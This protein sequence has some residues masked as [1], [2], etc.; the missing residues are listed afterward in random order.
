MIRVLVVDDQHLVR[1]GFQVL[2]DSAPDC[3]VVGEAENGLE[4][5]ALATEH[6]PDVVLMDIRMPELDGIEAT[7]RIVAD[8][9]NADTHV[10]V[11]TTFDLDEYVFEA[12]RAGASGFLLKDTRPADLLEAVRIVAGGEALLSPQVTRRVI[13]E[14]ATRPGSAAPG[15]AEALAAL[16]EREQE[17]LAQVGPGP[18]QHRDRRG[19]LRQPG[20]GQDPREPGHDQAARPRPGPAGRHRLRERVGH[21]RRQLIPRAYAAPPPYTLRPTPGSTPQADD[22]VRAPGGQ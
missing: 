20:D 21:P 9:A 19:P 10:L 1:A 3:E 22:G 14:F 16:T 4:A 18:L 17:V 11:L 13:A 5:V 7:R 8:D 15:A 6:R 2:I 12:L